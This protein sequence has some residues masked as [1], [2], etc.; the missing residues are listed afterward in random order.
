M[1]ILLAKIGFK[2]HV[3]RIH[4]K[5]TK[6]NENIGFCTLL[7]GSGGQDLQILAKFADLGRVW[8]PKFADLCKICKFWQDLEVRICRFGQDLHTL[9][10]QEGQHGPKRRVRGAKMDQKG[11]KW[12]QHGTKMT[13]YG[14]KQ[15]IT[16]LL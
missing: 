1:V 8:N 9:G 5:Y 7:V 13:E 16:T 4:K 15:L 11:R 2:M 14:K 3:A 10:G 12:S 6:I